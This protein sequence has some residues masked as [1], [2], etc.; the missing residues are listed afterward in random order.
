MAKHRVTRNH[1]H[2]DEMYSYTSVVNHDFCKPARQRRSI[3]VLPRRASKTDKTTGALKM[4]FSILK[5][6]MTASILLRCTFSYMEIDNPSLPIRMRSSV[7]MIQDDG[8]ILL[9]VSFL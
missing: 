9:A 3:R 1:E 5:S 7:Q 8:Q 2:K 6:W 4:F